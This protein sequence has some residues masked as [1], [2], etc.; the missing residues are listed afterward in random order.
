MSTKIYAGRL[1]DR[2]ELLKSSSGGAFTALSDVFLMNGDAVAASVYDYDT[3]RLD[4]SIITDRSSRDAARGSKY[5]QSNVGNIFRES[6][7]WLEENPDKRLMFVGTGCQAEAF[8]SYMDACGLSDRIFTMD[9]ICFGV[10][11]PEIWQSY[12]KAKMVSQG[13]V[14]SY[15]GLTFKD[16]RNSWLHPS[17][18]I[19]VDGKELSIE[20]YVKIFYSKNALRRS[21]YQCSYTSVERNTDITIGD[22]WGIDK[23]IPDF[24]DPMGN[25]LFLI[26]TERGKELFDM[27]C[28]AMEYKESSEEE[29]MQSHLEKPTE[30]PKGRT[31]FWEIY[32]RDGIR[33]VMREYATDPA[34]VKAKKKL[35][36]ALGRFG[37]GG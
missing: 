19:S 25:S 18:F 24:Y 33:E 3:N 29:C 26:H 14:N 30:C 2:E 6:K 32:R 22:F 35:K 13:D 4:F 17:A 21:C 10:V 11:S 12:L 27:A 9:I 28:E 34:S 31:E 8:R 5:F 36:K 37:G 23:R 20:E 15:E 1:K 7:A 16:K